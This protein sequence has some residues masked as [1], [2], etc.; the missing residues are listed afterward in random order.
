MRKIYTGIGSRKT[1][2]Q[3]L[4][5]FKYLAFWLASKNYILRSGAAK[6]ADT[7]FETGCRQANGMKEIYLPFKG[8][9]NSKS[10]F[11]VQKEAFKI[12]EKFH[13]F[14]YK[15]S[16]TSKKLHARN[17][18]QILG[19]TL[20]ENSLFV[21]CWTD[22]GLGKGGTGQALRMAD[23]YNIPIFDGG[24]YKKISILKEELNDFLSKN[25]L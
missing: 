17:A 22:K 16:D 23:H 25:M 12:A 14:W 4:D 15:L 13:P 24:K 18:H 20:N 21:I 6:G 10:S 5:I 3:V 19:K 1:P 2:Q 11:I 8:F 9:N 7:A